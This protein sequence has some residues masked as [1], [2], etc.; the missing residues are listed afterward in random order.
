MVAR[1]GNGFERLGAGQTARVSFE[2]PADAVPH[3]FVAVADSLEE[4]IESIEDNN[5]HT[6]E[7]NATALADLIVTDIAWE[8]ERPVIREEVTVTVTLQNAGDG[9]A[10]DSDVRLFI[11]DKQHGA[12]ATLPNLSSKDSDKVTFIWT[13]EVGT[14]TFSADVDHDNRVV[15][16]TKPTTHR[17][18]SSMTTPGLPT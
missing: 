18:C 11:D 14:H 7:Y 6:V 2:W 5:E 13:A 16:S 3:Q 10:L 15:E 8:P 17:T 1:G 9:D 12:A 4:V